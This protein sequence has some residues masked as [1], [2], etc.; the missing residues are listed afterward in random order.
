VCRRLPLADDHSRLR[1]QIGGTPEVEGLGE[2]TRK[3]VRRLDIVHGR[4]AVRAANTSANMSRR[5][6]LIDDG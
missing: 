5:G 2:R 3:S 1:N 4:D 6:D